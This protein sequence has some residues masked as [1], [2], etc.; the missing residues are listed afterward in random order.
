MVY[1]LYTAR[2]AY[3]EQD[4]QVIGYSIDAIGAKADGQID[5]VIKREEPLPEIDSNALGD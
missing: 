3:I 5:I 2:F 4:S 1:E